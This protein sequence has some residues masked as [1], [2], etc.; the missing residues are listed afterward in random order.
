MLLGRGNQFLLVSRRQIPNIITVIRFLLVVPVGF[1]LYTERYVEALVLFFVAG[2][3]DGVDGFLAR[4]FDWRTRFGAVAD[5]LADKLLLVTAFL[6]L[7]LTNQV[8]LWLM[9][10]VFARD[11]IIVTGGLV[12]HYL[13]GPYEMSPTWL[14]KLTTF[15]QITYV[16]MVMLSLAGVTMPVLALVWG[17]WLVALVILASGV[18]Y[19]GLWSYKFFSNRSRRRLDS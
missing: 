15:L 1:C 5:P 18:H 11:L 12:Y 16:L 19:V 9:G 2:L 7:A 17:P 14:G 13:V 10:M 8:P 6:F 4:R 3:S